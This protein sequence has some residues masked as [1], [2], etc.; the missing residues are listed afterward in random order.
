MIKILLLSLL[1]AGCSFTTT[2]P[3]QT[4]PDIIRVERTFPSETIVV[5][6]EKRRVDNI[7]SF[8]NSKLGGWDVPIIGPP[9]GQVYLNLYKDNKII[10]NFY[11]GPMFFGR[12]NGNFWS[13][14][15]DKVDIDELGNLID[16]DLMSI[17]NERS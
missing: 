14:P 3:E 7:I 11:V 17:I 8:I 13:Q 9:V 2:L 6:N 4:T 15:A 10:G 1:L 12:D 16:V 5:I